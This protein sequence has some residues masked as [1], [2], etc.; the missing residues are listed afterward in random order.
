MSQRLVWAAAS[1]GQD[2]SQGWG[3]SKAFAAKSCKQIVV[4]VVDASEDSYLKAGV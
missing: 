1:L 4:D 2:W 3:L